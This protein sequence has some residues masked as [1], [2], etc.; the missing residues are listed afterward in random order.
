MLRRAFVCAS[1]L[2]ALGAGK[3][4]EVVPCGCGFL[5]RDQIWAAFCLPPRTSLVNAA[6]P[7]RLTR[8]G[9]LMLVSP[10]ETLFAEVQLLELCGPTSY[11]DHK[12]FAY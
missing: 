5:P 4:R 8:Q 3:S 12:F 9:F 2:L 6:T 10:P 1:S 11:L 7:D